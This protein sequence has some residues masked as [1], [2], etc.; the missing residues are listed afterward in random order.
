MGQEM[1]MYTRQ[2]KHRGQDMCTL[3]P[4][5]KTI[6]YTLGTEQKGKHTA[7]NS[8]LAT[9]AA[10]VLAQYVPLD[11]ISLVEPIDVT[12]LEWGIERPTPPEDFLTVMNLEN[13][14]EVFLYDGNHDKRPDME[15]LVPQGDINRY[16]L[17]YRIDRDYDGYIDIAYV[18]DRRD[19]SCQGVRVYWVPSKPSNRHQGTP[20]R[21][22]IGEKES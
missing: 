15:L 2:M 5:K 21:P 9:T 20:I 16:P 10:L 13:G 8:L 3:L 6:N 12:P 19:G 18:D 11:A 22:Q 1:S 17:F 7:M 14:L 4:N